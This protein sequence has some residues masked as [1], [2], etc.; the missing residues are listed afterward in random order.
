MKQKQISRANRTH[1]KWKIL[2]KL[3]RVKVELNE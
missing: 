1:W 2:H 3:R